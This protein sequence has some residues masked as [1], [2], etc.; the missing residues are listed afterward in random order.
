MRVTCW[1]PAC[2]KQWHI[3]RDQAISKTLI[4]L[5]PQFPMQSDYRYQCLVQAAQKGKSF[6]FSNLPYKYSEGMYYQAIVPLKSD[7]RIVGALN[8]VRDS[9]YVKGPLSKK[10]LLLPLVK[11]SSFPV[12]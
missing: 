10:D 9:R 12:G 1:N 8:I 4:E 7:N 3:S 5:F 11:N 2:E 6:Y